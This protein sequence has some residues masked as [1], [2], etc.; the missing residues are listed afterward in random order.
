MLE[1]PIPALAEY[2][3]LALQENGL[4]LIRAFLDQ[5]HRVKN[6]L[7]KT[8]SECEKATLVTGTL[9]ASHLFGH[10]KGAFTG[11]NYSRLGC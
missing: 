6:K 10:L 9:F 4:G 1:E 7:A 2:D 5:W 3:G 8:K 11:A